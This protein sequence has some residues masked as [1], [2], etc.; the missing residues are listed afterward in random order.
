M[1]AVTAFDWG[2]RT[3]I[4]R[5]FSE[6]GLAPSI[7]NLATSTGAPASG[8]SLGG[9]RSVVATNGMSLIGRASSVLDEDSS[10]GGEDD[11]GDESSAPTPIAGLPQESAVTASRAAVARATRN[12]SPG[13]SEDISIRTTHHKQRRP[14]PRRVVASL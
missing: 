1:S 9:A 7:S 8:L 13:G 5:G 10:S 12:L 4:Y 2:V 3:L 14:Q 11:W 6:H